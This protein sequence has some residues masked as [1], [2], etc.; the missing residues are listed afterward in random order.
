V[1]DAAGPGDRVLVQPGQYAEQLRIFEK[2]KH[3]GASEAD[4]IVIE[5]DPEAPLGG[6]IVGPGAERRCSS[7]PSLDVR[8]SKF[9]TGTHAPSRSYGATCRV[10]EYA[11]IRATR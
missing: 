2:N 4:R 9:A 3:A 11:C 10:V 8:R 6:V 7:R 5:A 1:I